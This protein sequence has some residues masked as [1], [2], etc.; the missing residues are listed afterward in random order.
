[1]ED[2]E[3]AASTAHAWSNAPYGPYVPPE[4]GSIEATII[5]KAAPTNTKNHGVTVCTAAI[6]DDGRLLRLYP[7]PWEQY[8]GKRVRKFTRVKV[9]A[10]PSDEAARRPESHK[11]QGGLTIVSDALCS[12]RPTPWGQRNALILQSVEPHG[13]QGLKAKQAK[14][15]TSLGIV[16]VQELIDFEVNGDPDEII[17]EADYRETAQKTLSGL[18]VGME[19]SKIDVIAHAFRFRWKC[20]GLCC[21]QGSGHSMQCEDWEIMQSF[22]NWRRRYPDNDKLAWALR[23]KYYD[24]MADKDLH[25][26]LGT[27][28]DPKHQQ[29][30][31]I[32]GIYYPP[33]NAGEAP[34]AKA[35][36][37]TGVF[38]AKMA[39][40][41]NR[42][43][44]VNKGQERLF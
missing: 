14:F 23:N 34:V 36:G 33:A 30:F 25:F 10:V 18:P 11:I 4:G 8:T 31:T 21:Q 28:S 44:R 32:I 27:T 5:V 38:K 29:S 22:R 17:Q 24:D 41:A 1:M 13:V 16:K 15:G 12:N 6:L 40:K 42:A 3:S 20:L 43:A 37:K 19:G 39:Q 7:V 35:R 9:H 2:P 26:I